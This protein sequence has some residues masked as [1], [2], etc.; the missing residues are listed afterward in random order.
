MSLNQ[1]PADTLRYLAFAEM[2]SAG[3]QGAGTGFGWP[4]WGDGRRKVLRA[5]AR[6]AARRQGMVLE[7]GVYRGASLRWLAKRFPRR[8]VAG[9]DS[10]D[11]FPEDGR[12]DWNVDFRMS[13]PPE[14]GAAVLVPGWFSETL[15]GFLAENPGPA[16]LVHIDCDIYSSTVDVLTA[17]EG[18]RRIEPG[19][20]IVFDELVN[21]REYL[22]NEMLALWEMLERTGLG[23][24]PLAASGAVE[25]AAPVLARELAGDH[26]DPA[27][28]R[29][30]GLHQQAA[31]ELVAHPIAP[32]AAAVSAAEA[33]SEAFDEL[34]VQRRNR[35]GAAPPDTTGE[36]ADEPACR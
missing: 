34:S 35:A 27:D 22:W 7:F 20:V 29:A 17:L 4:P 5:A 25:R 23:A 1:P 31:I 36:T 9:F 11:G 16:A 3:L 15:P 24:K 32:N 33:A 18:A 28:F 10:L 8:L 13:A 2:L 30:R 26:R 12:V 19:L 6:R 14:T 21:Y